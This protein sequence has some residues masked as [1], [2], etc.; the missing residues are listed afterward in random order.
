MSET[1]LTSELWRT[2]QGNPW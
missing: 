1:A 2:S